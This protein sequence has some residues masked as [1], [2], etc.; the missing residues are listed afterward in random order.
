MLNN[1]S[2]RQPTTKHGNV[3][4]S[5]HDKVIHLNSYI[6]MN[7]FSN[8]KPQYYVVQGVTK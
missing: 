7:Q 6:F 2:T 3:F 1:L 8:V 5:T 4:E